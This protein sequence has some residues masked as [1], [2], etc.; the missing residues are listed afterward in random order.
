[1]PRQARINLPG[2]WYH[3][4]NRGI[5]KR[6]IFRST[7]CYERFLELLS[8]LPERFDIE[9]LAYVLMP[10]HYHLQLR[11]QD[12]N[13]SQAI[14]WLNV[15]YSVWFNRKY[16]RVGPLFQGR[17]KAILHDPSAA[18]TISEVWA[19]PWDELVHSRGSGARET[20]L[21]IGQRQGTLS[22]KQ[23]GQLVGGLHQ[24]A[25]SVAVRR[26]DV[27][28]NDDRELQRKYGL[29]QEVLSRG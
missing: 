9:M 14:H 3:V 24:N 2:A 12:A 4:L 15:N 25:V 26:L 18:L 20:A 13:L 22:L 17:F 6:P 28:L 10:N 5:E 7:R 29:V 21:L 27:R 11:T 8:R 1:M 23:L 16:D 19:K